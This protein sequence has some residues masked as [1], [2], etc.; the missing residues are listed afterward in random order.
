[1]VAKELAGLG[2]LAGA[3]PRSPVD[4]G[5]AFLAMA[6]V[7]EERE[8]Q[9]RIEDP[10]LRPGELSGQKDKLTVLARRPRERFQPAPGLQV[11]LQ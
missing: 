5:P 4:W 7:P 10:V 1:V 6:L 8:N 3:A 9:L 11:V 2:G